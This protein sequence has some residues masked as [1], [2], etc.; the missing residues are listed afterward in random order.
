M[1]CGRTARV[2]RDFF[3]WV[4]FFCRY[5]QLILMVQA[6]K[7]SSWGG[8]CSGRNTFW[9]AAGARCARSEIFFHH[10]FLFIKTVPT[11]YRTAKSV[12]TSPFL[13]SERNT[14]SRT[15]GARRKRTESLPWHDHFYNKTVPTSYRTP[16]SVHTHPKRP[17]Q[18]IY[19]YI[20]NTKVVFGREFP[21][22]VAEYL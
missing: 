5:G 7:Q 1:L 2:K 18:N 17:P 9:R 20:D 15:A 19:Y 10:W 4:N 6:S 13:Y 3:P 14:F 11:T 16:A 22:K 21:Q 12:H 8:L